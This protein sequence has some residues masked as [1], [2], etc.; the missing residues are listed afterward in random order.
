MSRSTTT[1]TT[2]CPSSA[3]GAALTTSCRRHWER[4]AHVALWA[5]A[6]VSVL[7]TVGIV[8]VLA[9]E[10]VRFFSAVPVDEFLT[11]ASWSPAG[12]GEAGTGSFGLLP[13]L[14]G[15]AIVA[16]GALL[17]SVPLGLA[18]AIY[19][20]E[21]APPR[22]RALLKPAIELLAGIPTV[23]IGF[24]ALQVITPHLLRPVFGADR[25]FVFNGAA[26][27]IAVGIMV[28][29]IIA[30]LSEDA[31]RAVPT[32]LREAARGLGAGRRFT[33]LRVVVPAAL[34]GISASV[35]LAL[36]RAVGET[37]IVTI[38]A[39]STPVLTADPFRS[40]QTLTA[41]IAHTV[42]GEA[43]SGTTR[44][45]SLFAVGAALFVL[46]L[47]LNALSTRVVRRYR[48]VYS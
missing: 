18:T 39:G 22:V 14:S 46:T 31:L 25:V 3:L 44:Y 1:L 12:T 26:G 21:Y 10:A 13:L 41:A 42:S 9:G 23:V 35:L 19:L 8:A 34:S 7:A 28:T 47:T 16:V 40:I 11:G 15:T 2:P 27:A 48:E 17:V 36:S 6:A 37:M 29:P 45:Q 33:T 4:P 5:C 24:F 20:A 43:A 30:S 38:A 32:S